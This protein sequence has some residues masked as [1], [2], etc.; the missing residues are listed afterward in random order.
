MEPLNYAGPI[1]DIVE[2]NIYFK[3][4]KERTLI[5]VIG[6]QKWGVILG[7]PWLIC[8]N[9]EIDW[10]MEEVQMMRYPEE[11]EKKQRTG[12]QMKREWQK[13]KEKENKRKEFRAPTIEKEIATARIVEEK[14]EEEEDLI[15][16][17]AVKEIVP[18][19]FHRYLKVFE[20]KESERMLMRK[21]WNHAIDF[22]EGFVPKKWKIYSLSRVER[23]EVQEFVK[24]QL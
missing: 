6:G 18:K 11:C 14:E 1:V 8:H 10:R 7:I 12:R 17:R 13:Q 19:W 2:I 5:D 15:E 4:H 3:R 16:L 23:G 9:Q 24:D 22:R 21:A 20:K